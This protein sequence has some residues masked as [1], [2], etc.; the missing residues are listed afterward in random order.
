MPKSIAKYCWN[1]VKP[2]S[3]VS[4]FHGQR[5]LQWSVAKG[6]LFVHIDKSILFQVATANEWKKVAMHQCNGWQGSRLNGWRIVINGKYLTIAFINVVCCTF[7]AASVTNNCLEVLQT[8]RRLG[9]G[10][11]QF[12]CYIAISDYYL[13]LEQPQLRISS[14]NLWTANASLALL[15]FYLLIIMCCCRSNKQHVC[16]HMYKLH[17]HPA[18]IYQ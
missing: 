4:C 6:V 2:S 8:T 3:L 11:C 17:H 12:N 7:A 14:L 1:K 13:S 16:R 9:D 18:F 10:V 5:R 15:A